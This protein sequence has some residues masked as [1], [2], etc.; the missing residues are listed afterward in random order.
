VPVHRWLKPI[1]I[2]GVADLVAPDAALLA[3][4]NDYTWM[5]EEAA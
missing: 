4:Y 5:K 2:A 3:G 1:R